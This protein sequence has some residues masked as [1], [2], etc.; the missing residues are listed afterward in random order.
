MTH[1][2]QNIKASSQQALWDKQHEQRGGQN[3]PEGNQLL[4]VPN[5]AAVLLHELLPPQ[6][7]IAEI[8]SANG[9]D[10]RFWAKQ[11]HHVHCLDFSQVALRQLKIHAQRQ[12]LSDRLT[13][14]LFDANTGKLP[15][16]IKPIHG[17]YARSAL[18]ID[19]ATLMHLL[20]DVSSCLRPGGVVVIEGKNHI[21]PKITRSVRLD[22]G[23]FADP[24]EKGHIRRAW[25]SAYM[26]HL[27]QT[28]EWKPLRQEVISERWAET[29][30]NFLRLV[31]AKQ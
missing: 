17:F 10:A 3:G 14:W 20:K 12:G 4:D 15:P 27:C 22:N 6:S 7:V 9:R 5:D 18:H 30:V 19:D 21:D 13:S 29:T 26:S 1:T 31:A 11:G 23:L 24:Y 28:F 16:A 8:G 2:H 25:T